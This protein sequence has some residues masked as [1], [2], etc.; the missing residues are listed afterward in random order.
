[1]ALTGTQPMV[2]DHHHCHPLLNK[3]N[4]IITITGQKG[5][6]P[7]S[8]EKQGLIR[9]HQEGTRCQYGRLK[10]PKAG[11]RCLEGPPPLSHT[12]HCH[13]FTFQSNLT[14]E[15]KPRGISDLNSPINKV[16][17]PPFWE[18]TRSIFTLSGR[19]AFSTSRRIQGSQTPLLSNF[20][21]CTS[22]TKN[23]LQPQGSS[24]KSK[25]AFGSL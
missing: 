13:F 17:Q 23:Q 24:V 1:M 14:K 16:T 5:V 21:T 19:G 22:W 11:W 7:D 9:L 8:R 12:T 10:Q 20:I 6:G 3:I 15:G 25:E 4:A 18:S 2:I